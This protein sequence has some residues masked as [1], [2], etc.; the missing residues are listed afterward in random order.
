MS[1]TQVRATVSKKRCGKRAAGSP[2][3]RIADCLTDNAVVAEENRRQIWLCTSFSLAFAAP[4]HE[5]CA[6]HVRRAGAAHNNNHDGQQPSSPTHLRCILTSRGHAAYLHVTF[7]SHCFSQL[8]QSV[9]P[10]VSVAVAALPAVTLCGDCLARRRPHNNVAVA[11][12]A[13]QLFC[14]RIPPAAAAMAWVMV[15]RSACNGTPQSSL[16]PTGAL[17]NPCHC[18]QT[19]TPAWRSAASMHIPAAVD[20]VK[21]A[22]AQRAQQAAAQDVKHLL[23]VSVG[24]EWRVAVGARWAGGRHGLPWCND[25]RPASAPLA[26][27][28]EPEGWNSVEESSLTASWRARLARLKAPG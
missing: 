9:A 18:R 23:F 16:A 2:A 7:T 10:V 28:T 24:A 26:C 15:G 17:R 21:V 22:A 11:A 13:V 5:S 4:P 25:S 14:C 6:A 3:S 12:A 8:L 19:P 20:G 27:T 1:T